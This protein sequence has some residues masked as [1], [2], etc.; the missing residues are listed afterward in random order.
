MPND[1]LPWILA[2]VVVLVAVGGWLLVR[3][4]R[5]HPTS[6]LGRRRAR[7]PRGH[8]RSGAEPETPLRRA[9]V[10]INPTKFI[11]L[12]A[13]E[14]RITRVC[15]AQGWGEP[16]FYETTVEDP[17]RGPALRAIA[18]GAQ[19]VCS[20]GGDGTVRAVASGLV[21]T[22]TPLGIL[23]AG[24]GNVLA[25]NLGLPVDSLDAALRVA[26][27]GRNR[28]ID[29]GELHVGAT[30]AEG[31]P[32][33]TRA[34][35]YFLILA[36]IGLDAAIMGDTSEH[37]KKRVG[38]PAYLLSGLKNLVSPEFR[39]TIRLDGEP[40]FR[41]RARGVMIGNTG[42]LIAGLVLMPNALVDDGK[43]DVVI[44][45]PK[46]VVGWIPVATRVVTRQRKGHP[47]LDH[48]VCEQVRVRTDRP[49]HVQVDGDV[50]GQVTEITA[51]VRK[52]SLTVRVSQT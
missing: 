12:A 35:H 50:V 25:R 45:S 32:V 16:L 46:G 21:G 17:G 28:R 9:A 34:T 20:L 5:S 39:A 22:Q 3:R 44:A 49:L 7:P 43:L 8:F 51:I 13:V 31:D 10:V 24:T 1:S 15:H 47:T 27:S 11:D 40:E 41:R 30:D 42:R 48:K 33:L 14:D 4:A 37:L 29:V 23:P 6:P 19:V 2:A 18:D 26:L 36:G 38:W 52:A